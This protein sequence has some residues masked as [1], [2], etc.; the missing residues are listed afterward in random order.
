MIK[1]EVKTERYILNARNLIKNEFLKLLENNKNS[2]IINSLDEKSIKL[3][4]SFIEKLFYLYDDSFFR[5]QLGKF[6]GDKIKFS[7]SKRMTS[8]GGK[9]IYSKTVQGFNYEIR[10]SLPVLNNFYLTNSEKRVSGLVVLDP[11]EALMIIM[12]HEICHVIEF[13]NYGQSNC[14]AYRFKKISRE[15][16]N[17]KGIY[18]EIPSR[19]SLSKENKSINISVGDKVKFSYKDKTYEGLVFNIT[20]RAT[21]M[22]LDS[23]GQYKDKKGNRYGKWYVPL[24][25]LRK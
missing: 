18:H 1:W 21:V 7:I 16:F 14:K 23:K 9:T 3:S 15:I 12:E 11:I 6:I 4:D 13:N 17:H 22:V 19:K 2:F 8:A 5:G 10:I 20:K 25:N 24:S